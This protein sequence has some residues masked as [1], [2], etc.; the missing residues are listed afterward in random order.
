MTNI[1][2]NCCYG[3]DPRGNIWNYRPGIV[4]NVAKYGDSA[5]AYSPTGFFWLQSRPPSAPP[6]PMSALCIN[7][8]WPLFHDKYDSDGLSSDGANSHQHSFYGTTYYMP[9]D[10]PGAQHDGNCPAHATLL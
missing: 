3:Y 2:K 8:H 4:D 1:R 10:F 9:A 6:P 5:S 7:G